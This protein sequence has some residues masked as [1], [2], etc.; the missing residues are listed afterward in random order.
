M[1]RFRFNIIKRTKLWFI[2][3]LLIILPGLVSI[4]V[5]GFNLGI[6]F[7]GGTI[8]DVSFEEPVSVEQVRDVM[9]RHGLGNSVIQLATEEGQTTSKDAM[10][11]TPVLSEEARS[12]VAADLKES[13]GNFEIKRVELVGSVVGEELTMNAIIAVLISWVLIV[14]YIAYRFEFTFGIAAIGSLLHD[15]LVVLGVFSL[16]QYE[17]DSAFIAAILTVV[18]YSINDTIVI[19]DRIRE[20]LK[21]RRRGGRYEELV[22]D[23]LWQTM[24]RSIYTSVTVL[25][26]VLSLY[27][28]GGETTK[29]FALALTIGMFIGAY[30]S[31]FNAAP[32]WVILANR[33]DKR[34]LTNRD[35]APK[36]EKEKVSSKQKDEPKKE[37][38]AS[39]WLKDEV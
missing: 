23:S 29:G 12:A 31:I 9:A 7:T 30:S 20:N 13:I 38:D 28:F 3:S 37:Y 21:L 16:L 36:K 5:Q 1:E 2:L 19:F 8:M 11:R 24:T 18:G 32:V 10:I 26:C 35:N 33:K 27:F 22:E 17:I 15:V 14:L 34:R 25:V 6:D 39:S 4:G